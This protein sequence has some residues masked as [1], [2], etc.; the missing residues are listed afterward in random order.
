ME[1]RIKYL[2]S[3]MPKEKWDEAET[4]YRKGF[5]KY[6][7][8]LGNGVYKW[9]DIVSTDTRTLWLMGV[10]SMENVNYERE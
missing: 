6:A 1:E 4:K 10:L 2:E 5:D 8:Y 7:C 3:L 9:R